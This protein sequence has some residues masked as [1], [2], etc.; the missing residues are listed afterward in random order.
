MALKG[1]RFAMDLTSSGERRKMSSSMLGE[2]QLR[3]NLVQGLSHVAQLGDQDLSIAVEVGK[4]SCFEVFF[5]FLKKITKGRCEG[6]RV[7]SRWMEWRA[8]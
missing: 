8:G 4:G 1:A 2:T 5:F 3:L 6:R 7:H